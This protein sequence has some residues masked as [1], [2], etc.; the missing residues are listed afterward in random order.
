MS[1]IK[2]YKTYLQLHPEFVP[3]PIGKA[4]DLSKNKYNSLQPIV[5]VKNLKVKNTNVYW[6][7]KCDCG[8]YTVTNSSSLVTGHTQSCGCKQRQA[9]QQSCINEIGNKYGRL[10]VIQKLNRR[11]N[12]RQT[13]W[14]CKCECGG[15]TEARGTELRNGR[16]IS[17]G[18]VQSKGEEK[19]QQI[20]LENKINFSKQFTFPDLN[21]IQS[22]R[23]DF[24]I[25]NKDGTIALLI[26]YQGEQHYRN[27]S[28]WFNKIHFED[29]QR[30]DKMKQEYC[31]KNN[32][33]LFII[34]YKDYNKL[35]LNYFIENNPNK[36]FDWSD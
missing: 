8:N 15:F 18:C 24:C 32:I 19:I 17:C 36:N 5:R 35:D 7:C 1:G 16:K 14:L 4:N 22:L 33:P 27:T 26:E 29:I 30:K 25:F 34:S 23:F 3:I 11:S 31:L 28:G 9:V 13:Y 6:L 21:D 12:S 10:T 2:E 20:L